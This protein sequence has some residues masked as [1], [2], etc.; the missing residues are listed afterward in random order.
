MKALLPALLLTVL[1]IT[2]VFA[3]SGPPLNDVCPVSGKPGRM[4]YRTFTDKGTI[5]FCCVDCQEAYQKNPGRYPIKPKV[6]K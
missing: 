1:G 2:A 3:K 4:I 5:I 6:E